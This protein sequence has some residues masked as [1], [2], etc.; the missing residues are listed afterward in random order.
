MTEQPTPPPDDPAEPPPAPGPTTPPPAPGAGPG[1][2]S[3]HR[4]AGVPTWAIGVAGAVVAAL[5]V[6]LL[7]TLTG[8][9]DDTAGP[10]VTEPTTTAVDTTAGPTTTGPAQTDRLNPLPTAEDFAAAVSGPVRLLGRSATGTGTALANTGGPGDLA[11]VNRNATRQAAVVA[12]ARAELTALPAPARTDHAAALTA[13]TTATGEH[14]RYLDQLARATAGTPGQSHLAA[15]NRARATAARALRAYREF[16][17]LAPGVPNTITNVGL[18]DT[19]PVRAAIEAAI[20]Q[21][22]ADRRRNEG[23][24]DPIPDDITSFQSPTGNIRCQYSA[25]ELFCSTS[26]DNFA[27]IL[28]AAGAPITASGTAAGGATLSYGSVWSLGAFS[29]QSLTNGLTCENSTSNGFFLSRDTFN[30]W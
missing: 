22:E 24:G 15:L 5:V 9:G 14:R 20:A 11:R 1:G 21:R 17:N 3:R 7:I 28:P 18:A 4:I 13:I 26:N 30:S 10:P 16:F 2:G 25:A 23:R 8:G 6:V 29:C 27:V 19:A 12:R